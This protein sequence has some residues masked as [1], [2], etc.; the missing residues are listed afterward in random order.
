MTP[1]DAFLLVARWFH[2]LAAL[3]WIGGNL[4]F[5]LV[6]RPA[7]R[8]GDGTAVGPGALREF[9]GMVDTSIMVL[10]AT[11]TVM[12][13][14]RLTTPSIGMA[15]VVVLVLKIALALLMFTIAGRRWRRR[16]APEPT[17]APIPI[18]RSGFTA[19]AASLMSGV[20]LTALLGIVVFLLSDLLAF[21][22]QEGLTGR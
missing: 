19:R 18:V 4:F 11:G 12:L 9:R 13:F 16:R 2:G 17:S 22:F 5:V 8:R 20:N 6:L 21:L 14:D 1:G 7:Q 3:F 10:V 15:Y